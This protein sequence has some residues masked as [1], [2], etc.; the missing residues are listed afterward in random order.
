MDKMRAKRRGLRFWRTYSAIDSI[1]RAGTAPEVADALGQSPGTIRHK[2]TNPNRLDPTQRAFFD[3]LYRMDKAGCDIEPAL[4]NAL[5]ETRRRKLCEAT[6]E[7]L[8]EH[9]CNLL[10]SECA[11]DGNEDRAQHMAAEMWLEA[12]DSGLPLLG[13]LRDVTRYLLDVHDVDLLAEWRARGDA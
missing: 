4:H 12:L 3:Q 9:G 8:I 13:E 10:D 5:A 7:D 2:R 1:R 6:V 11:Y